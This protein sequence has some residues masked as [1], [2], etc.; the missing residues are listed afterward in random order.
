M[1]NSKAAT[2]WVYKARGDVN[3]IEAFFAGAA[4]APHRHDTYTIG[5]TLEGVQ[6][7]DYRGAT[8]HSLP[9]GLVVLH[10]DEVHDGRAGTDA[11]FR[12]RTIYIQPSLIQNALGGKHLPFI[13]GGTSSDPRL[14][15]AV[16]PLLEEYDQPLEMLE[17]QDALYDL[18]IVLDEVAGAENTVKLFNYNAA[19][20]ARQYI[21]E[22]L[23]HGISLED[24][25]AVTC[26]DRWQ[27][28]RDFRA[29][30]GTSPH[31]YL[32]M[33]RLD[34]ARN[35]LLAGHSIAG[36]AAA[37]AFSDQSHF[38]RHFKKAYGMTPKKWAKALGDSAGLSRTIVL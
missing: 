15:D 14:F 28:S 31:R 17:Y 32:T 20:L 29:L 27:L 38:T 23:E 7:F 34:K 35:M 36:A 1:L 30:F 11:G 16:H 2:N 18:A 4:Y 8:R 24:L 12:Y 6:S 25:E 10:P 22:Q 13:E 26:H 3:R 33:R 21:H 19:R 9:G 37:S 5:I